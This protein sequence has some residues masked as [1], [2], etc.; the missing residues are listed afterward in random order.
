[1]PDGWEISYNFNPLV[2]DA[3][4]D[5]DNDGATNLIEYTY[6]SNP[7]NADTDGDT[8]PDGW[9]ITYNLNPINANDKTA[10]EDEDGLR[11]FEE[12][13]EGTDPT[14]TDTDGDGLQIMKR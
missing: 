6:N 8:M 11:N 9:E 14:E 4:A 7:F 2:N 5:P 3:S 12:F 1:M 10:D 13:N